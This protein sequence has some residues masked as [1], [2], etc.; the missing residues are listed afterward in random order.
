MSRTE[1]AVSAVGGGEYAGTDTGLSARLSARLSRALPAG[2][3]IGCHVGRVES[4]DNAATRA[5]HRA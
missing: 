3:P 2:R 4:A 1:G 5:R